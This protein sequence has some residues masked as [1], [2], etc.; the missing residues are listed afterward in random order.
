MKNDIHVVFH[1]RSFACGKT[2]AKAFETAA[3]MPP[4]AGGNGKSA[5]VSYHCVLSTSYAY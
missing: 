1:H 5:V 4:E 3:S 2:P